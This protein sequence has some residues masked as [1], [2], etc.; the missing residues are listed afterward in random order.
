M[1]GFHQLPGI[2]RNVSNIVPGSTK[3][4]VIFNDETPEDP[5]VF[6]FPY[7]IM[8]YS[9]FVLKHN[10]DNNKKTTNLMFVSMYF[11]LLGK[12]LKDYSLI[13]TYEDI[14]KF[15]DNIIDIIDSIFKNAELNKKLI[16]VVE[17]AQKYLFKDSEYKKQ[18]GDNLPKFVKNSLDKE[19]IRF[20]IN[21]KIEEEYN[22]T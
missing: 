3:Y 10:D 7:A 20:L 17:E 14:L 5:R 16:Q 4:D 1:A 21:E 12:I 15:D 2:A 18:V 11:N 8:Y 19:N 6:L 9:K 13:N 22:D